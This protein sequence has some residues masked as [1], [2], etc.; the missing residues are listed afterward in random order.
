MSWRMS[1]TLLLQAPALVGAAAFG[2]RREGHKAFK[3]KRQEIKKGLESWLQGRGGRVALALSFRPEAPCPSD[4][5]TSPLAAGIFA[6]LDHGLL[7][8]DHHD[9]SSPPAWPAEAPLHPAPASGR[10]GLVSLLGCHRKCGAWRSGASRQLLPWG[11]SS[12][13]LGLVSCRRAPER[14]GGRQSHGGGWRGLGFS[15][16]CD[17]Q[18]P[19][20][21]KGLGKLVAL[22]RA[23]ASV[24]SAALNPREHIPGAGRDSFPG[25]MGIQLP[26]G[27]GLCSQGLLR[28]GLAGRLG[29]ASCKVRHG[30]CCTP[31]FDS[32]HGC[33]WLWLML[34]SVGWSEG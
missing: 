33:L 12:P 13:T 2:F 16:L 30:S 29:L 11:P 14:R 5:P 28:S 8:K 24:L 7:A 10:R 1:C 27:L 9:L 19:K 6:S 21:G 32:S 31:G 26:V 17:Y 23:P 20:K 4:A 25:E 22:G 15:C 18:T 3:N 34:V